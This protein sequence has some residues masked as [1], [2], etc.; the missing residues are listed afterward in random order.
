[1][2]SHGWNRRRPFGGAWRRAFS[3]GG[4]IAVF[5]LCY[6]VAIDGLATNTDHTVTVGGRSLGSNV[7]L[8]NYSERKRD[9]P[10]DR[11]LRIEEFT[12]CSSRTSSVRI[13]DHG[14]AL[15]VRRAFERRT[16]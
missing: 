16:V 14:V 6:P 10:V 5:I 7:R 3:F 1:M 13:R 4:T 11:Q 9:A 2:A 8:L 12:F 15:A